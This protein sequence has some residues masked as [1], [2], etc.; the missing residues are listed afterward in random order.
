[1]GNAV[2]GSTVAGTALQGAG[3]PNE[4]QPPG[5]QALKRAI[6][7]TEGYSALRRH[8][9]VL[10]AL[11]RALAE[12][13]RTAEAADTLRRAVLA[14]HADGDTPRL[15]GALT[16]WGVSLTGLGQL[17][18]ALT[19]HET[20]LELMRQLGDWRNEG[21]ALTNL[22]VTLSCAKRFEEAI[23]AFD[24]AATLLTV[25]GAAAR[26]AMAL[27]GKGRA[28]AKLG[29]YDEAVATLQ[30]AADAFRAAGDLRHEGELQAYL[31]VTLERAGRTPRADVTIAEP[32]QPHPIEAASE[33]SR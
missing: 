3:R 14:F 13:G 25:A 21:I 5:W 7:R 23:A 17:D 15:A 8:G 16:D 1:M 33:V 22:G 6:A 2:M 12:E 31:V 19:A 28:L 30:A 11:G 32:R 24:L 27:G 29:R 9:E 4:D 20:S 18:S 10:Q 26:E